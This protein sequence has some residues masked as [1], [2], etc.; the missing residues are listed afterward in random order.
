MKS[1]IAAPSRK[2]SGF[3]ATSKRSL[4]VGRNDRVGDGAIGANRHGGFRYNDSIAG[5]RATDL[6]GGGH[7]IGQVGMTIAAP[8]WRADGNEHGLDTV[9]GL[10][11][12]CGEGQTP[13]SRVLGDKIL[14]PRLEDGNFAAFSRSIFPA[15]RSTQTTSCPKSEKH[16]PDTR[17][18]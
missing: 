3:E 11:Q 2:N 4:R 7:H 12:V 16:A 18:T 15:S 8:C 17:P 10:G 6:G 13:G 9:H 1:S 14:K 5:Q